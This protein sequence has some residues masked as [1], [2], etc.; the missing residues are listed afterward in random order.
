MATIHLRIQ[1]D[2]PE[3]RFPV[4]PE[5]LASVATD[6]LAGKVRELGQ[7]PVV[8]AVRGVVLDGSMRKLGNS[9]Y[10]GGKLNV[11]C[12]DEPWG[13]APSFAIPRPTGMPLDQAEP[14]PEMVER[15]NAEWL[16]AVE[17]VLRERGYDPVVRAGENGFSIRYLG[18]KAP[19]DVVRECMA[20]AGK[21]LGMEEV[22]DGQQTA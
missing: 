9:S 8:T 22:K 3:D 20:E 10:H 14:T 21:R 4:D 18:K 12:V 19:D 1:V 17:V 6:I 5:D 2:L 13:D 15:L 16:A 7:N 11:M